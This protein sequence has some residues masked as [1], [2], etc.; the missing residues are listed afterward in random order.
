MV[1]MLHLPIMELQHQLARDDQTLVIR[2][3]MRALTVE[4]PLIPTTACFNIAHANQRL[5]S[6]R[7]LCNRSSAN[8]TTTQIKSTTPKHPLEGLVE[9]FSGD[10]ARNSAS[11][12]STAS[13]ASANPASVA[14]R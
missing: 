4:Q 8:P 13:F 9:N 14:F 1:M 7:C 5:R 11:S 12:F 6:H 3:A 2:T 10:A